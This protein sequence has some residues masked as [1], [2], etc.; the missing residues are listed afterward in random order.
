MDELAELIGALESLLKAAVDD[1]RHRR[2]GS[3]DTLLGEYNRIRL[4]IV[5][6]ADSIP[7]ICTPPAIDTVPSGERGGLTAGGPPVTGLGTSSEKA[8]YTEMIVKWEPLL[9][10]LRAIAA[11]TT[12][13]NVGLRATRVDPSPQV[14]NAA[15]VFVAHGRNEGARAAMFTFLRAIGLRPLEWNQMKKLTGEASP[16]N[17]AVVEAGIKAARGHIVLLT[18]DDEARVAPAL[19]TSSDAGEPRGQARPNVLAEFGQ[20]WAFG[21]DRTVVVT[22]GNVDIPSN[23][24]G[25][26]RVS[27]DNS[28]SRRK[29]LAEALKRAQCPVDDSGSDW[30]SAE[31]GGDFDAALAASGSVTTSPAPTAA[32]PDSPRKTEI[33]CKALAA[34]DRWRAARKRGASD[35]RADDVC[36]WI[37]DGGPQGAKLLQFDYDICRHM[38]V[39]QGITPPTRAEFDTAT[40]LRR[41]RRAV[42]DNMC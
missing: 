6:L 15:V 21:S 11:P 34:F 41:Q 38:C 13:P 2:W 1:Q 3:Y 20:V 39:V 30:L 32:D 27:I 16:A 37:L 28:A 36:E 17:N 33:A 26:Q 9:K 14:Q 40:S 24:A 25:I 12:P 31:A 19:A 29:D 35:A 22:M 18:P 7:D 4:A 10:K 5:K 8:K 42:R 23:F